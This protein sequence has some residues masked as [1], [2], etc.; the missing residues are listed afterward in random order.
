MRKFRYII[1][2]CAAIIIYGCTTAANKGAIDWDSIN[3]AKIS[4]NDGDKSNPC[5]SSNDE[6]V[7]SIGRGKR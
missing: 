7:S 6:D 1:Y 2:I 4:C 5:K 3:Y